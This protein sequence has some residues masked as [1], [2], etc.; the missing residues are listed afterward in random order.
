[1]LLRIISFILLIILIKILFLLKELL[2]TLCVYFTLKK[3]INKR[4]I[5]AF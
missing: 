4:V 3:S 2:I 5:K 1:M